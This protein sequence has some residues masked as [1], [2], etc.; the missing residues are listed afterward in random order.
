V[1]RKTL[2]IFYLTSIVLVFA[3]N[4]S[5][6]IAEKL[7]GDSF[8]N[9]RWAQPGFFYEEITRA[10]YPRPRPHYVRL[11]TFNPD[12][13][14]PE[15]QGNACLARSFEAK[16][17]DAISTAHPALIVLDEYFSRDFCKPGDPYTMQ[18]QGA[19]KRIARSGIPIVIGLDSL[20]S[21]EQKDMIKKDSWRSKGRLL[22]YD[23]VIVFPVVDFQADNTS[24][25]LVSYGLANLD[26]DSRRIPLSWKTFDSMADLEADKPPTSMPSLAYQAAEVYDSSPVFLW[27]L[28][29]LNA[30]EEDP[31]TSF[32]K[33]D[34][35]VKFE[36]LDLMCGENGT[37]R[38]RDW[39]KCSPSSYG[40]N[41]LRGHIVLVGD[42]DDGPFHSV[43]GEVPGYVLQ[44]NYIEGLL[45]GR[46]F[47][48]VLSSVQIIASFILFFAVE[49]AF[50]LLSGFP[51]RA[52]CLA[53]IFNLIAFLACC[54]VAQE[55][56]YY[57]YLW[58]PGLVAVLGEFINLLSDNRTKQSPRRRQRQA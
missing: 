11:V 25:S 3:L 4:H 28:T 14:P 23:E 51:L 41:S 8:T 32:L 39:K 27:K 22:E 33:E 31:F 5:S 49:S 44:T 52:I 54:L 20:D 12:K 38:T 55:F 45:D 37:E 13:E 48:P 53:I 2:S 50:R 30:R 21:D 57:L 34:D 10:G 42:I 43:L 35:F 18:L 1:K 6:Y 16:L 9:S 29:R 7:F 46:V 56:G 17:L 47:T 36:A 58:F 24:K 26:S 19:V 40:R 15:F